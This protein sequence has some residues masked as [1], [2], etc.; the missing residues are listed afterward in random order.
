M[1]AGSFATPNWAQ[2]ALAKACCLDPGSVVVRH[3]DSGIIV[4]L[5]FDPRQEILVDKKTGNIVRS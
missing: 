5:Q 4:F 3:E 2:S 1:T